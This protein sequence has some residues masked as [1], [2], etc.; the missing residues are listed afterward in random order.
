MSP[1]QAAGQSIYLGLAV[2]GMNF[3]PQ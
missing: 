2:Q 1:E 3:W